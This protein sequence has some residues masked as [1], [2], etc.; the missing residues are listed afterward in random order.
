L[1]RD[2]INAN[3]REVFY[4]RVEKVLENISPEKLKEVVRKLTAEDSLIGMRLLA[5]FNKKEG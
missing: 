1:V 3:Y 2:W 4:H 5:A